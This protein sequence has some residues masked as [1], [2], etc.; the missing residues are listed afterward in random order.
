MYQILRGIAGEIDSQT[1]GMIA[2]IEMPEEKY[3]LRGNVCFYQ[4]MAVKKDSMKVYDQDILDEFKKTVQFT[5]HNKLH[6]G[7]FP[8]IVIEDYRQSPMTIMKRQG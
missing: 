7:A 4:F 5:I 1:P 2:E 6:S 8:S 3:T